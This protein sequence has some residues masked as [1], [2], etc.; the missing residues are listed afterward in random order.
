[1]GELAGQLPDAV[2]DAVALRG[3]Y[4]EVGHA[5]RERY[6]GLVDRVASYWPFI[7][8]DRAGWKR[9]VAAFQGG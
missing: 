6:E 3:S 1:M 5:L 8:A 9:L 7:P 2:V 4:E